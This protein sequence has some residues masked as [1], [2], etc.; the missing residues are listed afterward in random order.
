ML[1]DARN[2]SEV[3]KDFYDFVGESVVVA[4]NADF[5]LNFVYDS[6][7]KHHNLKFKNDFVDTLRLARRLFK[8][9][10]HRLEDLANHFG[11]DFQGGHRAEFD[12]ELTAKIF[13][14]LRKL[15]IDTYGSLEDFE[16]IIIKQL[17]YSGPKAKDFVGDESKHQVNNLL[18][19]KVCVITVTLEYLYRKEAM[20][21]IADIGG[22]NSDNVTKKTNYLILGNFEYNSVLKGK[23]SKKLK[24]AEKYILEGQDLEILSEN[25]FYEL[26]DEIEY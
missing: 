17:S 12:T 5:D 16:E 10:H 26:I 18:Y 2:E 1:E 13:I 19:G 22:I 24:K 8:L 7:L 4:H 9:D 3:L 23:K 15:V 25:I 21:I 11:Y 14:N 6:L 20:Q